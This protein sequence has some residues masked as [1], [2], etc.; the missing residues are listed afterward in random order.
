VAFPTLPARSF[1]QHD[2][3]EHYACA[4]PA[5]NAADPAGRTPAPADAPDAPA[6]CHDGCLCCGEVMPRLVFGPREA[7]AEKQ[8]AVQEKGGFRWSPSLR[9]SLAAKIRRRR[10]MLLP[11]LGL[12][13]LICEETVQSV[14]MVKSFEEAAGGFRTVIEILARGVAAAVGMVADIVIDGDIVLFSTLTS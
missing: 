1:W 8:N 12:I 2:L 11:E 4:A 9:Q 14:G 7:G 3:T 5:A 13:I 10:L 6:S